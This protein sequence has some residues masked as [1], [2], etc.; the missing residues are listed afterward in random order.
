MDWGLRL[1]GIQWSSQKLDHHLQAYSDAD[2][3]KRVDD[4]KS[5][6]GYLTQFWGSTIS[7]SSQTERTVALHTTESEY[8]ALSMLVQEAVHLRQMLEKLKMKQQQASEVFV[9]NESAKKLAKNPQFHSRTKH[10]DARHHFVRE[11]IELKEIEMLRVPVA[12]N[13]ADIFT[14]PVTRAVFEKHRSFMGLLPLSAYERSE[15]Q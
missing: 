2:F 9:D 5:V 3:A 1:G 11:R 6:A 10:I 14:K 12:D 8:M 15:N 13:V 4:R 7:W